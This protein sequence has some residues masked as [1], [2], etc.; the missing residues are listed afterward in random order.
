MAGLT[1]FSTSGCHLCEEAGF[2]LAPLLQKRQD[3]S[4]KLVDIADEPSLMELY[5][6]RIPVLRNQDSGRELN[7]PFD[8][9]DVQSIL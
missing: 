5:G 8:A 4:L 1:L 6:T 9:E 3:C 2:L 7:W